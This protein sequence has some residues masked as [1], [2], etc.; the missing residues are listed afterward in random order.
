MVKESNPT[1]VKI[2][3]NPCNGKY[4][5]DLLLLLSAPVLQAEL[6]A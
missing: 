5:T 4:V 6:I 1:G 2:L 3:C